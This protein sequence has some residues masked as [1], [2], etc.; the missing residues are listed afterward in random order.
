M[1]VCV[2]ERVCVCARARMCVCVCVWRLFSR[3][4]SYWRCARVAHRCVRLLALPLESRVRGRDEAGAPSHQR[5][6]IL[7]FMW[8]FPRPPPD[9][10]INARPRLPG[11]S[12]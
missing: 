11:G 7:L 8:L 3:E 6:C 12:S 5:C 2:R 1:R 4:A 10:V 9:S